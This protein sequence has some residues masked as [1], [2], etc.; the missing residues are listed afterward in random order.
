[1]YWSDFGYFEPK[2][3]ERQ[4]LMSDFYESEDEEDEEELKVE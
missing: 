1:M 2:D 3:K 4:G